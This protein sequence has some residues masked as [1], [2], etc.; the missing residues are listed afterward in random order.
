MTC[1]GYTRSYGRRSNFRK[2]SATVNEYG[3]HISGLGTQSRRMTVAVGSAAGAFAGGGQLLGAHGTVG[4]T[5][6]MDRWR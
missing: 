5:D 3:A 1:A 4:L 2:V 6:R